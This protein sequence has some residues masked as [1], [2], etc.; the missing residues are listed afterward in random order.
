MGWKTTDAIRT[1]KVLPGD[2]V[3][4]VEYVSILT[5]PTLISAS[6]AVPLDS[7]TS[8][9]GADLLTVLADGIEE[10]ASN[11]HV[12]GGTGTQAISTSGFIVD[13]VDLT[14][15]YAVPGGGPTLTGVARVPVDWF[16]L[17]ETGIGGLSFPGEPIPG[18]V[19][20]GGTPADLVDAEYS[21]LKGLAG[22]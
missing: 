2:E 7:Y 18:V 13:V 1:I 20:V 12:I 19:D 6:Y 17:A 5:Q 15:A 22:G 10:L 16:F 11:H 9:A 3:L 8:G 14:V 4:D 21:R